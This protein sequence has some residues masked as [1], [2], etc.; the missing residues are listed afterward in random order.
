MQMIGILDTCARTA[1]NNR[2]DMADVAALRACLDAVDE[3][4]HAAAIAARHAVHLVHDERLL[5]HAAVEAD[6]AVGDHFL[7][8]VGTLAVQ[9]GLHISLRLRRVRAWV[10][11]RAR[12][13]VIATQSRTLPRESLALTSITSKPRARQMILAALVL[14]MPGGPLMSTAFLGAS[15]PLGIAAWPRCV[16][17]DIA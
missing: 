11:H 10:G 13:C 12:E 3:V 2:H 4:L 8:H 5:L 14:P 6:S 9:A 17:G 15:L 1:V 7:H 16:L